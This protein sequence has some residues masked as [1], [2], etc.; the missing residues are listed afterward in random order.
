M[1]TAH[2]LHLQ[3]VY[4]NWVFIVYLKWWAFSIVCIWT[5]PKNK[6]PCL[7]IIVMLHSMS[8][9]MYSIYYGFCTLYSHGG[10]LNIMITLCNL[11]LY[12]DDISIATTKYLNRK[13]F[14]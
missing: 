12:K 10:N 2:A 11:V 7:F 13:Y 9:V 5:F 4:L 3:I 6:S 8:I 14:N 1:Y